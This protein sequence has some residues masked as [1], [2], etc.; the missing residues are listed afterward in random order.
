MLEIGA[1]ARGFGGG[2]VRVG[3]SAGD[4]V[5]GGEEGGEGGEL[6]LEVGEGGGEGVFG[7][8][9]FGLFWRGLVW[10]GLGGGGWLR[11]GGGHGGYGVCVVWGVDG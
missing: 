2:F 10:F 5:E 8:F 4:A 3:G 7:H 9:F 11:R 1:R 6:G